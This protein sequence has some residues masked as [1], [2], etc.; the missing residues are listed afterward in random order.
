MAWR[1]WLKGLI[2]AVVGGTATT[3]TVAIVDPLTFNLQ[4]GLRNLLTVMAVSAIFN[5]AF[6]L[7]EHPVPDVE[8]KPAL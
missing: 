1:N 5:G 7:K 4:A 2:A 6:Y 8:E 3:I